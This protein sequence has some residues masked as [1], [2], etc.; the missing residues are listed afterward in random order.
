[1]PGPHMDCF[2]D[3]YAL[4]KNPLI[5]LPVANLCFFSQ[6]RI[7]GKDFR[8]FCHPL[9]SGQG[10]RPYYPLVT[11][12]GKDCFLLRLSLVPEGRGRTLPHKHTGCYCVYLFRHPYT[13]LKEGKP[14]HTH[15]PIRIIFLSFLFLRI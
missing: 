7:R 12:H 2:L 14:I 5:I 6:F 10:L 8:D 4:V 11:L 15:I 1:M 13:K 9:K 3:L